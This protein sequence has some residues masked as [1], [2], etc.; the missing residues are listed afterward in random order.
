MKRADAEYRELVQRAA[1]RLAK[2]PGVHN[3]GIGGRE[4]AG[5]PT[6]QLVLKVFLEKKRMPEDINPSEMIPAEIEGLP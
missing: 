5:Q 3:I 1:A 2:L 6:G 4:R